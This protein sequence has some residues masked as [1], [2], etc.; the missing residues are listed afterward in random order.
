MKFLKIVVASILILIILGYGLLQV[1]NSRS[2]QFFGEIINKVDT[3]KKVV[4]L[5]FDD[6]PTNKTD[7][8]L[9]ILHEKNIKAT[10]FLTGKEIEENFEEAKKIF[11][12]GHEIGNHTYSHQRMVFKSPSFVK[13]EIEKTD[14]LIRKTGYSGEI[15]FRPPNGKKLLLLPKYLADNDRKSILWDIEPET[16]PEIGADSEKIVQY[17]NDHVENGSIILLHVMYDSRQESLESVEGII[18]ELTEQGYEFKT[19][20]ELLKYEEANN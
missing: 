4:A 14:K 2:F 16:D 11:N 3:D 5:T 1:I 13:D 20:S 7:D 12:A 8:I 15:L 18:N 19:V 10:F 9:K 6:G 17:V